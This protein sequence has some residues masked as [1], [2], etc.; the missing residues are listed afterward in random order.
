MLVKKNSSYKTVKDLKGKRIPGGFVSQRSI[1]RSILAH[2]VNAG[3]SYSDVVEVLE[4]NVVKAADDFMAGRVESFTFGLGA[5]KVRE[6]A[7]AVGGL[8]ALPTDTSPE[9]IARMRAVLPGSYLMEVQPT[10]AFPEIDAAMPMIAFDMALITNKDVPDEVVY[11][12]VKALHTK[13]REL[14]ETFA[15]LRR[16]RADAMAMHYDGLAYHPGAIKYYSEIGQWPP[17]EP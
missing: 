2:L 7:A 14:I 13:S 9:A 8:R 1:R 15:G 16:F 10:P 12:I 4:P 11:K 17:K 5:A 6:A 3:L